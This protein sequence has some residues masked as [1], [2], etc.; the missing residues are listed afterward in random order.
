M[1]ETAEERTKRVFIKHFD[2]VRW[3]YQ[4][5]F[6][7]QST[8]S[9]KEF[10][11]SDA[12]KLKEKLRRTVALKDQPILYRL[13]L[14]LKVAYHTIYTLTPIDIDLLNSIIDRV[15][16]ADIK[17]IGRRLSDWKIKST[18]QSILNQQP[19]DLKGFFGDQK[20]NR[21]GFLN[22]KFLNELKF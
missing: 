8:Q 6:F 20:I 21:F 13:C 16:E 12:P 14:K 15:S 22:K 11:L 18:R 1:T 17:V 4:Y 5:S 7:Y 19:H 9:S 10:A 3:T 2:S